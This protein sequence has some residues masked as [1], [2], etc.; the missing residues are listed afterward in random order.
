MAR[1]VGLADIVEHLPGAPADQ[2]IDLH[3]VA[4][5]LEQGQRRA[6]RALKALAAGDPGVEAFH[7]GGQRPN[8]ADLAASVGVARKQPL[9][10]VFLGDG[11]GLR[12]GVDHVGQAEQRA[13]FVAIGERL[14]EMLAGVD[15]DDWRRLVDARHHVQE[16]G[17]VGAEARHQGDAAGE[18]ILDRQ[19]DERRRLD[20]GEAGLQPRGGD[21]VAE[22]L[23]VM[24]A[25]QMSDPAL[26]S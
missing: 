12:L 18:K 6:R 15:E 19:P 22:Q 3:P 4:F 10:R 25:H 2:R 9:L 21:L 17:G 14:R 1:Q 8:L 5:G 20:A 24:S 13:E 11:L 23:H 16:R 26:R 7:C